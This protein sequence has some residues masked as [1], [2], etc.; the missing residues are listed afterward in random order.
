MPDGIVAKGEIFNDSLFDGVVKYYDST[1]QYLGYATFKNGKKNGI[2]V[3]YQRGYIKD[4]SFYENNKRTGFGYVFN[5]NH[6][7]DYKSFF[8]DDRPVGSTYNYDSSGNLSYYLFYSFEGDMIYAAKYNDTAVSEKGLVINAKTNRRTLDGNLKLGVFLYLIHPPYAAN[9]YEIAILDKKKRIVSS[10]VVKENSFFY[11]TY[12][13]TLPPGRS[14]AIVMH[15]YN[16]Y[17]KRDDLMI[18]E[19]ED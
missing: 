4:S 1:D 15:I 19:I 12:L 17:K 10:E 13:D 6:K 3:N 8:Y 7:L 9:H 18:S 5:T 11:E 16:K 14:Y 2:S